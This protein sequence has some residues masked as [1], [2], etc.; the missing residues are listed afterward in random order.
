M[1]KLSPE[2]VKSTTGTEGGK[3]PFAGPCGHSPR[4]STTQANTPVKTRRVG[5]QHQK[6]AVT[7]IKPNRSLTE[8]IFGIGRYRY[9]KDGQLYFVCG[10]T[11]IKVTEHFA[12][13]GKNLN[14]LIEDVI[15]F[16][17]QR[18][19]DETRPAC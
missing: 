14:T 2:N 4:P 8:Q 16:S 7:I 1:K 12:S 11:R 5:R 9:S 6:E 17:A 19:D 3:T 18:Q 10:K 13:D 15:Q